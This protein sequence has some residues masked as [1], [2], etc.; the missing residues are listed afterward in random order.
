MSQLKLTIVGDPTPL[1]NATRVA[2]RSLRNLSKV[3]SNVGN[4]MNKALGAVG[5]GIGLATLTNGLKNATKAA[6]EDRKSQGLLAN[7][8]RNTVGATTEAI[9]GA[10]QYIKKTQLSSAVLDDEL[11][12]ALATAV[13]ATGSLTGGQKLLDVAL[14]V[15]AGTGKDLSTVTN[16]MAK[17]FNGNTASLKKLL[18]SIKDGSNFMG[19][20]ETQ[21]AG[22]AETAANLDPYKRL[23]VIFADIQ[24]TVGTALLPALEEF[25]NYLASPEGQE[26]VRVIVDLFVAM[27]KA[28]GNVIV[29]LIKNIAVVK[30]VVA[31][32]VVLK[33]GWW[34]VLAIVKL[35]EF[36]V[37]KAVTATK[38][39]KFALVSTGLGA[40]AV[41][42]G[43]L[44]ASWLEATDNAEE[45]TE[46]DFE[47]PPTRSLIPPSPTGSRTDLWWHLGYNSA[48]E[49]ADELDRQA[50]EAKNLAV[51]KA[52]EIAKAIRSALDSKVEGIKKTAEKFRDSVSVAF[53]LF[54]EDENAV[55]NVDYFK[56]K[57]QRMVAAAK[58][59][60]SNLAKINLIDKSGSLANELIAMGPAEGNI[61]AKALL[62]SGDLKDIVGLRTSLYGTGAQAGAV[63]AV[64][65][66]ATYEININ[67][68]VISASDIIKE[69]RLLEKKTGRKYLVGS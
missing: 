69:I 47:L 16:A 64:Q 57:L 37:L 50:D 36:G 6:S 25:S 34:A 22:A 51:E 58:G 61:A 39:L 44:A 4:N 33:L 41:A 1:K 21:F 15:S 7:A 45:Y 67:K 42:V 2:E 24:E 31:A 40:I 35:Y 27:G 5:L 14:D 18:P 8:L 9:A 26:N 59:F 11:R 30:A 46:I 38:A 28:V 63:S 68:A 10:E 53:G 62:A 55:F 43:T 60:A 17:A 49:Y 56:A 3:T 32:V 13:R 29:W 12:P 54:G 52:K 20:L 48:Q 19:Q 65:G 66:N 23:E